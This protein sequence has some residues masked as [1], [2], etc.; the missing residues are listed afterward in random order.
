[1]APLLKNAL[2]DLEEVPMVQQLVSTCGRVFREM[3]EY[4]EEDIQEVKALL[5]NLSAADVGLGERGE[6]QPQIEFVD[7][8]DAPTFTIGIFLLPKGQALPIHDH[9]GMTVL[10]KVLYGSLLVS[11]FDKEDYSRSTSPEDYSTPFPVKVLSYREVV[12]GDKGSMVLLPRE[13]GNLHEFIANSDCAVIDILAPP[14]DFAGGR[15]CNY[16]KLVSE[17][18]EDVGAVGPSQVI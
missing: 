9:P 12:D 8:I 13:K 3:R 5:D 14:Y 18:G 16:Y 1:M 17:G 10:S 15:P 11:R 6:Q 7:V 4:S 2:S